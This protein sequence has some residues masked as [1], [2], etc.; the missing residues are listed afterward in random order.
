MCII[1]AVYACIEPYDPPLDDADVN[2]LVVD[3]FLNV[4]NGSATV[5]ITRSL[6]VKST[7]PEP[8]E[9]GGAVRIEDGDGEIYLLSETEPG[10]YGGVVS[11]AS[12]EQT[13]RL[14]I[15]TL[16]AREY[17]SDFV[18]IVVTPPIDSVT[19]SGT[20][21]GL[22]FAVTTHDP[23]NASQYFRWKFQET[24]E[25]NADFNSVFWYEDGEIVYRPLNQSLFTCWR[26]N[27]SSDILVASTRHLD[28]SMVNK[29]PIAFIA[30]TSIKISVGYSML[31]QQQS[32]TE[33]AYNYWSNLEKTTE[34]LGG[35]FDP[36]PAE[37]KGNIHSVSNPSEPVIGFFGAGTVE[38]QRIFFKRRDLPG[39]LAGFFKG[40]PNCNLDTIPVREMM[41]NAQRGSL[42]VDAVYAPGAG[43]VAY[44]TSF[45]GC[46][47][48]RTKG[49]TTI[50]PSFWK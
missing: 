43:I 42:I 36:L 10:I 50:K 45:S 40:N 21:D 9:T 16:G 34:N 37:V 28:Q 23:T 22:Q 30:K 41:D 12:S 25:Y 17:I 47:D 39:Y 26:T 5:S 35:L 29:F 27:L 18:Q 11:N 32:L 1:L 14:L 49:G 46:V 13:Y 4:T 7:V 48:C 38:E 44:T 19:W 8:P 24:Y 15:H 31:L 3:G 33:E 6:P 2:Y 20:P